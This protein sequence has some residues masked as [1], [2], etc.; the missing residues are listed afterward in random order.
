MSVVAP[1]PHDELELL[2]REAR[3][4]QRRRWMIRSLVVAAVAGTGVVASVLAGSWPRVASRTRTPVPAAMPSCGAQQLAISLVRT[5]AVMGQE[6]GLL[7]FENVS[8]SSC[9][10]AGWPRVAAVEAG[11][12]T[13]PSARATHGTMLYGGWPAGRPVPTVRLP[14]GASAYAVLAGGDTP[15]GASPPP[16]C[17]TAR[18]LVVTAPNTDRATTLSGWLPNDATNLP[19]CDRSTRVSPLL[20]LS[21]ILH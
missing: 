9:R 5:G 10:I 7:R 17:P 15:V 6:G 2:I 11:G 19:L 20:P 13:V 12:R 4:R 21:A 14:R 16:S 18:R 1:P 8:S 3:A